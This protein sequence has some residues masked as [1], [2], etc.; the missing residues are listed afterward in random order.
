[1]TSVVAVDGP[2]DD[3]ADDGRRRSTT[4]DDDVYRCDD[5]SRSGA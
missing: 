3:T 4:V 2:A 5:A 1:V